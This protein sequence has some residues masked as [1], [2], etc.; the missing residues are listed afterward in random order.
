MSALFNTVKNIITYRQT[1]FQITL[2]HGSCY[3][4]IYPSLSLPFPQLTNCVILF[5]FLEKT[6][7]KVCGLMLMANSLLPKQI[8]TTRVNQKKSGQPIKMNQDWLQF[9]W[10]VSWVASTSYG[11]NITFNQLFTNVSL[12]NPMNASANIK[13]S[14]QL[15]PHLPL[16]NTVTY[17][18]DG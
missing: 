11:S 3:H 5:F 2:N 8:L 14:L 9:V 6:T 12:F 17:F 4:L 18:A 10:C 1:N 15:P 7:H 13:Y 16:L